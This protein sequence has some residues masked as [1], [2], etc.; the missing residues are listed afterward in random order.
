M[1]L[2]SI[3]QRIEFLVEFLQLPDKSK[4]V[5]K[6]SGGQSRRVSL[7]VTLIHKPPLIVLDEPTV[8][9]YPVLRHKIWKYLVELA[10]KDHLT[11]II[12]THYIEEA[13]MTNINCFMRE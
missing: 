12:T 13:S 6:L 10:E 2:Y 11:V 4:M 8:G 7:A 3:R 9:L 1:D 5:G